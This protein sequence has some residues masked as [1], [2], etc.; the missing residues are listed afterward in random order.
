[1]NVERNHKLY[2]CG[3]THGHIDIEKLAPIG[4]KA[5]QT[6]SKKDFLLIAGD[7]GIFWEPLKNRT[8]KDIDWWDNCPWSTL[9]VDGNHENFEILEKHIQENSI[10]FIAGVTPLALT[11]YLT[12]TP[13]GK[14]IYHL[15]RGGIYDIN[16]KVIFVM[17][18]GASIDKANRIDRV[19]WWQEELPSYAEMS[20]ALDN[21]SAYFSESVRPIDAIVTHTC[22]MTIKRNKLFISKMYYETGGF[23]RG[24]F[25]E[26]GL[27]TFLDKVWK[28]VENN[29]KEYIDWY[30]G[31]FH[32]DMD[33]IY[34]GKDSAIDI[35]E[36]DYIEEYN[37]RT[38]DRIHAL[39]DQTP[40]ELKR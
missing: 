15:R 13:V 39:Y 10:E 26:E 12:H 38:G 28:Y 5:G 35:A 36:S 2:I 34:N 33:F 32:I 40:I 22:P 9:W 25:G 3:D 6:L 19:S 23:K 7:A 24:D 20:F 27:N 17:G 37:H 31:H 30:F 18:G 4:F 8:S 16:G 14:T 11:K 29:Q 21:L 1:M